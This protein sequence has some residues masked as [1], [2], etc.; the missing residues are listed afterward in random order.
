MKNLKYFF[1]AP[2]LVLGGL[3]LKIYF[4]NRCTN[5]TSFFPS[6]C[7]NVLLFTTFIL[8]A[9]GE[10]IVIFCYSHNKKYSPQKTVKNRL[11]RSIFTATSND[12]QSLVIGKLK[13]EGFTNVERSGLEIEIDADSEYRARRFLTQNNFLSIR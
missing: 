10:L 13:E 2:F 11:S 9:T 4:A 8:L 7:D 3:C 6:I 12:E 1:S 5:A